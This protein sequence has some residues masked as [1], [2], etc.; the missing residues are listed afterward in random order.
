MLLWNTTAFSILCVCPGQESHISALW[1]TGHWARGKAAV[2]IHASKADFCYCIGTGNP[3]PSTAAASIVWAAFSIM[4]SL[5][6]F[7]SNILSGFAV[8]QAFA[9]FQLLLS[10]H[11]W[12][13]KLHEDVAIK[14]EREKLWKFNSTL[15]FLCC[16][17]LLSCSSFNFHVTLAYFIISFCCPDF[18]LLSPWSPLLRGVQRLCPQ[19]SD[20]SK[21]TES[22][23][24]A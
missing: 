1:E 20:W 21:K 2:L 14:F 6:A 8:L 23:E 3:K 5:T 15:F 19:I 10:A 18:Q 7:W 24:R 12:L 17:P 4:S 11:G 9:A 22:T 13:T 16:L